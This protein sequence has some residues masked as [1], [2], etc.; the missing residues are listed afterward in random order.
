MAAVARASERANDLLGV[1]Y[2]KHTA[3]DDV[4]DLDLPAREQIGVVCVGEVPVYPGSAE[5]PLSGGSPRRARTGSVAAAP[6]V[7]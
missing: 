3:V 7:S 4:G 6:A 1:V 5:R 2:P